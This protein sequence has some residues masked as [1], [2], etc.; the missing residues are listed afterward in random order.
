MKIIKILLL[1]TAALTVIPRFFLYENA[2]FVSPEAVTLLNGVSIIA[3]VICVICAVI[4]VVSV[5]KEEKAQKNKE[6]KS[7]DE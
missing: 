5:K 2:E 3:A 6:I 1:I 7:E 4:W